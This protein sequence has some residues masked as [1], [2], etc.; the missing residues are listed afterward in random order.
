MLRLRNVPRL[1]TGAA[2]RFFDRKAELHSMRDRHTASFHAGHTI[3]LDPEFSKYHERS[4]MQGTEKFAC[5][6]CFFEGALNVHGGCARCGSE[7]VMSTEMVALMA[8]IP[9]GTHVSSDESPLTYV[10]RGSSAVA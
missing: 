4:Q 2:A 5:A 3:F 7:S 9:A 6:N 1:G 8:K 10:Y